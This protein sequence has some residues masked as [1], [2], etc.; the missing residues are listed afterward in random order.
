MWA[1]VGGLKKDLKKGEV[2]HIGW[3]VYRRGD[4]NLSHTMSSNSI[5][6]HTEHDV[7]HQLLIISLLLS[8]T[9]RMEV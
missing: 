7:K 2:G 9:P 8:T 4:L 5:V 1:N 3:V 6:V